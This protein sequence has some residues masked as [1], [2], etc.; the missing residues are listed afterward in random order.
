VLGVR[1]T[2]ALTPAGVGWQVWVLGVEI[3]NEGV[4]KVKLGVGYPH[5]VF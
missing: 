3:D 1:M 4:I 5:V 2:E